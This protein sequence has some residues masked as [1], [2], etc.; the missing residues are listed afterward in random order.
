M[1]SAHADETYV[2][3]TLQAGAAGYMLKESLAADFIRFAVGIGKEHNLAARFAVA[4]IS[5]RR[6]PSVLLA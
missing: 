6:G 1:L 2:L 3:Q 4:A 5:G